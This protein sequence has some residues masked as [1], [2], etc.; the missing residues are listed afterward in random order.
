MQ[1]Q[2]SVR[3]L[4]TYVLTV[5][6][7]AMRSVHLIIHPAKYEFHPIYPNVQNSLRGVKLHVKNN[8]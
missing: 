7:N 8:L 2:K 5:H 6:F 3:L 4:S 1:K